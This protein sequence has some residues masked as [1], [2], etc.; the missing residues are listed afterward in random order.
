[1]MD[2][3]LMHWLSKLLL[4]WWTK[5][6]QRAILSTRPLVG[7]ATDLLTCSLPWLCQLSCSGI[8]WGIDKTLPSRYH[9]QNTLDAFHLILSLSYP[10][11]LC[12]SATLQASLWSCNT[13]AQLHTVQV[14]LIAPPHGFRPHGLKKSVFFLAAK[15]N[16]WYCTEYYH[17]NMP[18]C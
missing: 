1:M 5:Q 3:S 10:S 16:I 18:T 17:F 11:R 14:L 9:K 15:W 7:H 6:S 12:H 4:C 8:V 13:Y 2:T